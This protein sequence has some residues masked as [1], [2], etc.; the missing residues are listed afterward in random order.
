V[1]CSTEASG[2]LLQIVTFDLFH[3]RGALDMQQFGGFV[4]YPIG[5]FKD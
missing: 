1:V 3:Q 2:A 5:F 4:L